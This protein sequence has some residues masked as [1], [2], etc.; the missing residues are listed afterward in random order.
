MAASRIARSLPVIK[1]PDG[2]QT[3]VACSLDRYFFRQISKILKDSL[4]FFL[5]GNYK[6]LKQIDY[7]I[8]KQV[9]SGH[10]IPP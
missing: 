4:T 7:S 8:N 1:R 9:I 6:G 5:E 10:L 2:G 3:A